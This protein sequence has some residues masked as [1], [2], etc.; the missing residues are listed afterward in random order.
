MLLER[1][2]ELAR[3]HA[4]LRACGTD[5]GRVVLIRGEAGIGKTTLAHRFV[6]DV[7]AV[8]DVIVGACD[9]LA[10]PQPLAPIWDVA[11]DRPVVAAAL[12]SDDRRSVMDALLTLLSRSGDPSVLVLE[13]T[14]WADDAT[15][16]VITFL[17]RRIDRANGLLVLTYRDSEI[18]D[19]HPL[20]RVLGTLPPRAVERIRLRP[21]SLDAVA[22]LSGRRGD[23]AEQLLTLTGGN[24]LFVTEVTAIGDAAV[25]MSVRDAVVA[26]LAQLSAAAR[27]LTELVAIVPGRVGWELLT[28]LAGPAPDL[29]EGVRRGLLEITDEGVGFRHEL[30]RRAVEDSLTADNRRRRHQRVLTALGDDADPARLV[31]HARG[32]R[33][34]AAVLVHAPRAGRAALAVSS[35]REAHAHFRAVGPRLDRLPV[36]EAA[37][38]AEDWAHAATHVDVVEACDVVLRAVELRR[39]VDDPRALARTLAFGAF[40]LDIN[41]RG[42]QG[43]AWAAEAV[44]LT[45]DGQSDAELAYALTEQARLLMI[46]ADIAAGRAAVGRALAIAARIDDTRAAASAG[47]LEG[48]LLHWHGDDDAPAI[49]EEAHRLAVAE[50]HRFEEADAQLMLG[51]VTADRYADLPRATTHFARARAVADDWELGDLSLFVRA[52]SAELAVWAGRWATAED[53]ATEV[54]DNVPPPDAEAIARRVLAAVAVRR[55]DMDAAQAVEV[56][57]ETAAT[58]GHRYLLASVAAVAAE[59]AWLTNARPDDR[60]SALGR[61]PPMRAGEPI[62]GLSDDLTFWMWKLGEIDDVPPSLLEGFRAIADGDVGRAAAFWSS[63]RMPYHEAVA[64]MHG[65]DTDA[66]GAVH[67]FEELGA[68]AAARRLRAVL[69][70]RGVAVPRGRSRSSREHI[71][72]LTTRQ[73]EVLDLLADGLSNTEIADQLFISHRTVENHVAAILRKLDV[74]TRDEAVATARVRGLLRDT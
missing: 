50:G 49:M 26:Q 31:H 51:L 3:L 6:A 45:D 53:D 19:D 37:D 54:L 70:G 44:D 40:V 27:D 57:W 39:Q 43:R 1:D 67:R 9:D 4:L 30:Q 24:P 64:R 72:G 74:S 7:S 48:A 35:H 20:R 29:R 65:D 60:S 68:D 14:H 63:R 12:R 55:G 32:A 8:S 61:V 36:D 46:D 17:G 5:G 42:A 73:A 33:D 18:D 11:R 13:D 71:A 2:G 38:I 23:D 28:E 34:V 22:T 15:M 59:H 47:I 52:C 62:V 69:R 58:I 41:G 21:L 10:T 66:V 56:A 25:P 16:D